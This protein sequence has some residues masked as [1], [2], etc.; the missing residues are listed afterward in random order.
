MDVD[1]IF[2][3]CGCGCCPGFGTPAPK[4]GGRD[5]WESF[6]AEGGAAPFPGGEGNM[7]SNEIEECGEEGA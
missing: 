3:G 4:A 2:G 1:G 5:D 7:S 6:E